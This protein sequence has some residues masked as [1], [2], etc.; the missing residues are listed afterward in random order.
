MKAMA[1]SPLRSARIQLARR[2]RQLTN[3][4]L[5]EGHQ[6]LAE[7]VRTAAAT[8][9]RP[10]RI[11]WPVL[12][13]DILAADL[14]RPLPRSVRRTRSGEPISINWVTTPTGPGSGGHTTCFRII[15]YLD[16]AGYDNRIFFYH[17]HGADQK[18][19]EGV[20]REYYGLTCPISD[21]RNGMPD[22][23][24]VVA[25]SWP[26]AYVA[27]NAACA[28]K[29]FY[30][31]QDFEPYF[32]PVGAYSV[33]AENTYRMGFHG[34][35]AGA[36]LAQK[37]SREYG[38]DADYFPFGC[39]TSRYHRDP[40]SRRSGVAFYVRTGTPRRGTELGLLALELFAKRQPHAQI[41]LFGE[42]LEGLTFNC[43]NHGLVSPAKLNEIYNQCFA[44]ICLSFTNV[45]LVPHEMLA[46]GCVP[47]VNDA[48]HNRIVLDNPYVRYTS[49]TPHALASALEDLMQMADFNALSQIAAE[50]VKSTTWDD[51]AAAV[52][53][54]FRRALNASRQTQVLESCLATVD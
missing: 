16:T 42:K 18:Y 11:A 28:G 43:I 30:F 29:R 19:F 45:S 6:G 27:F 17:I 49:P 7:R 20:A 2:G 48:E 21:I 15:K 39:D 1:R 52:D 54:A 38:M 40:V 25:T 9:M 10:K 4:L 8:W 50:S 24:A 34:I 31:V 35:T 12:P 14:S 51:A 13:E 41:H 23:D 33:I 53:A 22:A 46:A 47:V 3:I 26:T 44:G 37:L 5:A 32:E 36:W